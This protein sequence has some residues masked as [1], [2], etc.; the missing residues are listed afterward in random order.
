M[1]AYASLIDAVE[2]SYFHAPWADFNRRAHRWA[3]ANGKPMVGNSDLHD[4]RQLGR[5]FSLVNAN[6]PDPGA[7]CDAI[8]RGAVVL[9]T[10][11]VPVA[12]LGLVLG[13]M[14]FG[15]LIPQR[16]AADRAPRVQLPA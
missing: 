11:A 1:D 16:R 15:N 2:H 14:A 8:R 12:E 5:T 3:S 13:G 9:R 6:T 4:L 10:S 7:I